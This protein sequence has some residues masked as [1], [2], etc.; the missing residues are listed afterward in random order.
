M[1]AQ[2]L[3]V[4]DARLFLVGLGAWLCDVDVAIDDALFIDDISVFL[5]GLGAWLCCA[6]VVV[7]DALMRALCVDDI[8]VFFVASARDSHTRGYN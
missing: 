6:C 4:A 3:C 5:V 8:C 7:G 1:F 2:A